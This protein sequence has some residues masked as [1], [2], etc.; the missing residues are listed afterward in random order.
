MESLEAHINT[1]GA[2]LAKSRW[3][4]P[5]LDSGLVPP[6]GLREQTELQSSQNAHEP[7]PYCRTDVN[8][9]S[10]QNYETLSV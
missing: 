2:Q 4:G 8:K 7:Q 6:P 5:W 9:L 3:W 10:V 1:D